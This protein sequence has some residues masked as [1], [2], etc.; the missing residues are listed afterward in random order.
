MKKVVLA[1][2]FAISSPV[3]AQGYVG[4]GFGQASVDID[5]GL[6]AGVQPSI[7]DTDTSFKVFGGA[8][9]NPN[10]GLEVG[11]ID[12][13]ESS[14]RWD[15]GVDYIQDTAEASALYFAAIGALPINDRASLLV[16]AGFASW[17]LDATETSSLGFGGSIS[18]SGTDPMFGVGFQYDAG[19]ILLR[20]EFERF[21]DLGNEDTI[22][23]TDVDVIGASAAV[24]F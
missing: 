23:T 4:I 14:V 7:D 15:D 19:N 20:A 8:F 24:K 10:F 21:T 1:A 13:G 16:K 3:F 11:Y 6:I 9:I 18:E 2:L 5:A 12:F 22:G 17:D